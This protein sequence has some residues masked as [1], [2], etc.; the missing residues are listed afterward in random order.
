MVTT[1]LRIGQ[2]FLRL[3]YAVMKLFPVERKVVLLSRQSNRPSRDFVRLANELRTLDPSIQIMQFCRTVP[4][5]LRGYPSYLWAMLPQLF[6][7]GTARVAIVDGY[8]IAVSVL[9]HRSELTVIQM[10]HA[11]GAIKKF[12]FQS[13]GR[14]DG[15][16]EELSRIMHMH[17]NYD[18]VLC[19]GEG[20]VAV[21][22]EAFGIDESSVL[23][24][25]LPR[26]DHL[27]ELAGGEL[28]PSKRTRDFLKANPV[29]LDP[30]K[31]RILYAPTNRQG[32]LSSVNAMVD[33]FNDEKYTLIIK[34]HTLHKH[35]LRHGSA[36]DAT[37]VNVM[38]LLM[39]ADV[40]VTDYSAVALEAYCVDKP[41]YFFV[42]DLEEYEARRGL[43]I[44]PAR[45]CPTVSTADLSELE[46][47]IVE[48]KHD[49]SVAAR[50]KALYLPK[51]V[52]GSTHRVADLV[53]R[54]LGACGRVH[55]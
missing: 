40:L 13:V 26:I 31:P 39:Y 3:A 41:V 54:H 36:V 17:R 34:P 50:I 46:R 11:L 8:S 5:A 53:I 4:S 9:N 47:W 43:N 42:P 14:P 23:P 44:N 45:D 51:P 27:L 20:S 19:G 16:S 2:L 6:H 33:H 49:E 1:A 37:G 52:A 32:N 7:L 25:G 24:I 28:Q 18:Y 10:W 29:V 55:D 48:G 38:D 35:T 30:S 21:F 15:R 22:A 12:G